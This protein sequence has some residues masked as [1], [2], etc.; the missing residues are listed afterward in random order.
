MDVDDVLEHVCYAEE[1]CGHIIE[2]PHE[3][4]VDGRCVTIAAFADPEGNRLGLS[5]GIDRRRS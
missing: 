5:S 4:M 3:I 1:L 2:L